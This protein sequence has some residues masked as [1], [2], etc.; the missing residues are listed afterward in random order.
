M[1][2][3]VTSLMGILTVLTLTLGVFNTTEQSKYT[4]ESQNP[5]TVVKHAD[6]DHH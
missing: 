3:I 6:G 4:Y 1:K 2:K 5:I